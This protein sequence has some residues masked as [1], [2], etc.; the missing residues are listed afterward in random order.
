MWAAGDRVDGRFELLRRTA[1]GGTATVF[2]ALDHRTGRDV[3]LKILRVDTSAD[4]ARADR[5]ARWLAALDHPHVVAFVAAGSLGADLRFLAMEWIAGETLG[6][7]LARDETTPREAVELAIAI[8]RALEAMH[9][10]GVVH[11]DVKPSNVMLPSGSIEAAKLLDLG[12]ARGEG[13]RG[14][15][16]GVTATG[17]LVGT[18]GYMSPEQIR[19][20][21][22]SAA[23]DVFS[24]GCVLY[25]CL[26]GRAPF[27]GGPSATALTRTLHALA[28]PLG[29]LRPELDRALVDLVARAM[30]VEP[31]ERFAD[32]CAMREA[33]EA[34]DRD[35][36][37]ETHG[38]HHGVSLSERTF[39]SRVHVRGIAPPVAPL[40]PDTT[41][42][43]DDEALRELGAI[44]RVWGGVSARRSD[45]TLEARVEGTDASELVAAAARIA[46]DVITR[47]P[48]ARVALTTG[49]AERDETIA[50]SDVPGIRLDPTSARLL[51][52]RFSIT[53]TGRAL[54]LGAE[55]TTPTSS[56]GTPI[57]PFEGRARELSL[58]EGVLARH[59]DGTASAAVVLGPAGIGKTRLLR[60]ALARFPEVRVLHA[61]ADALSRGAPFGVV[62]ELARAA[63]GVG[64]ESTPEQRLARVEAWVARRA[65]ESSL[66]FHLGRLIDAAT[67]Q[68]GSRAALAAITKDDPARFADALRD[69]FVALLEGETRD[70]PLWLVIDDLQ[71]A[72]PAST[73]AIH[74]ALLRLSERPLGVLAAGRPEARAALDPTWPGAFQLTLQELS[75]RAANQLVR[76]LWPDASE[77]QVGQIVAHA[78]GN[79]LFVHEL[80][81]ARRRGDEGMPTSVLA[82]GQTRLLRLAPDARRVARA[83]SILASESPLEA[84]ETLLVVRSGAL[85][86][87]LEALERA[88]V[89]QRSEYLGLPRVAFASPVLQEAAYAMLDDDDRRAGHRVAAEWY[90]ARPDT[91]AIRLAEH[92]LRAGE[93]EPAL[94]ALTRAAHDALRAGD[95]ETPTELLARAR[96]LDVDPSRLVPLELVAHEALAWRGDHAELVQLSERLLE[97]VPRGEEAWSRVAAGLLLSGG[98]SLG[99]GRAL[100]LLRAIASTPLPDAPSLAHVRAHAWASMVCF[101]AGG[102]DIACVLLDQLVATRPRL[103]DD[104]AL[105]GW[106]EL[107]SLYRP[108]FVERDAAAA[109]RHAEAAALAFE[110]SGDRFG[111]ALVLAEIGYEWL[112]LGQ[113]EV[114]LAQLAD[115][116]RVATDTRSRTVMAYAATVTSLALARVGRSDEAAATAL[117]AVDLADATQGVIARIYARHLAAMSALEAGHA[118]DA[119]RW[120]DAARAV[121]EPPL[122]HRPW[123]DATEAF[124]RLALGEL[125]AAVS[126]STRAASTQDAAHVPDLAELW[127]LSAHAQALRAAD[128]PD[129]A[130]A[131][132]T[133]HD[134]AASRA[135]A[136]PSSLAKTYLARPELRALDT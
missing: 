116:A 89:V 31:A 79:P 64:P 47:W 98:P 67:P 93:T 11:R 23:T 73:R 104:P 19:G 72:D 18:P 92:W 38:G 36:L 25:R 69:A 121:G 32:G 107:A 68:D 81:E 110:R 119:M 106:L 90:A 94:E 120:M 122:P 91:P 41:R 49:V 114:A 118:E 96:A 15:G 35:R 30:R 54:F 52:E 46:H 70:A 53:R 97:V 133:L 58:L 56:R 111:L 84:L 102:A 78:G 13:A 115:A 131:L 132:T 135:A 125:D 1:V 8:A 40:D 4:H 24:L 76:R 134:R 59:E 129:A 65:A 117:R 61:R 39:A 95:W 128:L 7:R 80:V 130:D 136:L 82:V 5:E 48:D 71:W 108:R 42:V 22:V 62:S 124:A 75:E 126:L 88:G 113:P 3:A 10:L 100:E 16:D 55:L 101:R 9:A 57:G 26:A 33:L 103:G 123:M 86:S 112:A 63:L 34:L 74:E 37:G 44:A 50:E 12:I 51:D 109:L 21:P 28:V 127:I 27:A 85:D 14:E 66:S 83:L 60:E 29:E 105:V 17:A 6:E 99:M 87:A 45:G 20:E 43:A 77:L 2:R